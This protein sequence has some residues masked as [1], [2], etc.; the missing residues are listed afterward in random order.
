MIGQVGFV[1][2][3]LVVKALQL[4]SGGDLHQVL[5]ANVVLGQQHQVM[6]FAIQLGVTVGHAAGSNVHLQANDG[7]DARSL[8]GAEELDDTVHHA[9]VGERHR[10]L[11]QFG[12]PRGQL[13]HADHAV[14][15]RILAMHVQV[16]KVAHVAYP[17]LPF[18]VNARVSLPNYSTFC[19]LCLSGH[20]PNLKIESYSPAP[21][22]PQ[23]GGPWRGLW[24]TLG[25]G[26]ERRK[27]RHKSGSTW[28]SW[29]AVNAIANLVYPEMAAMYDGVGH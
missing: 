17:I 13:V 20:W 28:Q 4:A 27:N 2:A 3:R 12:G 1:Y 15:Q 10:R 26:N 11:A 21:A 14:Q 7:L 29:S 24:F 16:A 8:T 18:Q 6:G 25:E 22:G 9:V 23:S 5:V 19:I